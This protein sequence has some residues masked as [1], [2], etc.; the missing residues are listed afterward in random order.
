MQ[1]VFHDGVLSL[2][3]RSLKYG[4]VTCYFLNFTLVYIAA[5][6]FAISFNALT[7]LFGVLLAPVE[8]PSIRRI[9][10]RNLNRL[11]ANVPITHTQCAA[12]ACSMWP[13]G[14]YCSC[15]GHLKQPIHTHTPVYWPFPGLPR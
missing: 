13:V 9:L 1:S 15:C 12:Q 6:D 14:L 2:H 10:I 4:K 7:L 5:I 3:T 11:S 8:F